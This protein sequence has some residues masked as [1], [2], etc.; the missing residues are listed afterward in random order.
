[1]WLKTWFLSFVYIFSFLG[2][3]AAF[4]ERSGIR[5]LQIGSWSPWDGEATG[6][7]FFGARQLYFWERLDD[8]NAAGHGKGFSAL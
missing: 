2:G 6:S 4:S 8:N 1:M 5:S 7:V 3:R